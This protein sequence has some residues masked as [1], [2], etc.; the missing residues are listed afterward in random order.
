MKPRYT[1]R[2]LFDEIPYGLPY[3]LPYKLQTDYSYKLPLQ[4]N[5]TDGIPLRNT[6]TN[7]PYGPSRGLLDKD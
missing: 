3:E 6:P 1:L 5:L 2:Q 7:Y 4:S